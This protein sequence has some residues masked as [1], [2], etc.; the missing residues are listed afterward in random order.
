MEPRRSLYRARALQ[1]WSERRDRAA[2]P[3]LVSPRL[4]AALWAALALLGAA[5]AAVLVHLLR[6]A[7]G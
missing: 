5:G 6:E 7:G 1:A 3:R 2:F 4:F